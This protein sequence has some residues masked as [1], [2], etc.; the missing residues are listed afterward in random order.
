MVCAW[1]HKESTFRFF[2]KTADQGLTNG[3]SLFTGQ[4]SRGF[5]TNL[6]TD[7]VNYAASIP[8][9]LV[10]VQSDDVLPQARIDLSAT[11]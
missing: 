6:S 8:V 2:L 11:A 1:H 10:A 9:L 4:T 5:S 3:D 7:S